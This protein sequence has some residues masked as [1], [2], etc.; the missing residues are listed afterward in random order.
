M[1]NSSNNNVVDGNTRFKRAIVVR[2]RSS[3]N[4]GEDAPPLQPRLSVIHFAGE[5]W[6]RMEGVPFEQ[7]LR[8]YPPPRGNSSRQQVTVPVP[9]SFDMRRLRHSGSQ[10]NNE[11]NCSGQRNNA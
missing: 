4:R 2:S 6:T 1:T 3:A 10:A 8:V 11:V 9:F 7:T 5:E